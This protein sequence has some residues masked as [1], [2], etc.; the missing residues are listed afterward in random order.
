MVRMASINAR[1]NKHGLIRVGPA[2]SRDDEKI[3]LQKAKRLER[4]RKYR[5]R[6]KA[7][8]GE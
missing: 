8:K 2:V 4:T 1:H 3:A 6:K 7:A 5:S